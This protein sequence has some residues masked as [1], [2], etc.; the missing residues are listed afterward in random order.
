MVAVLMNPAK[1]KEALHLC[2]RFRTRSLS[3]LSADIRQKHS[4]ECR[5]S[6]AYSQRGTQAGWIAR[7]G[8]RNLITGIAGVINRQGTES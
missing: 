4:A 3:E 5:A 1:V 7:I 6:T 8:D 2:C